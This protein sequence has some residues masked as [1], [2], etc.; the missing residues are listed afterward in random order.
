MC[1]DPTEIT[2]RMASRMRAAKHWGTVGYQ[3]MT[4][5]V[6]RYE[7]TQGHLVAGA[8]ASTLT[9]ASSGLPEGAY[10]TLRTYH[11][12]RVLRLADH[13]RRLASSAGAP[14]DLAVL[15]AALRAALAACGHPES[16]ARI[17]FAPP[18]L[19]VA[20]EPF[21]PPPESAYRDGVA[22]AVVGA[23]RTHFAS[24]D[25][26]FIA[27]AEAE[28][29]R[30]PDGVHEGLLVAEDGALLEG[31]SS[32]FFALLGGVLRTEGDRALPGITRSL[33]LEV[34]EGV[35]P[36]APR[37]VRVDELPSVSEC[38]ITSASRGV[39]PVVHVD[40]LAIGGGV[41]GPVTGALRRRFDARIEAEAEEV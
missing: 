37:A 35:V 33:L 7:W 29:R 28:Y 12:S 24:K 22:C 11:G 16:R 27:T 14:L 15:R 23:Q 9:A 25:T 8:I 19:F 40:G 20:V 26:R 41:P 17:T 5:E 3:P 34:A 1:A 10:T 13:A 4:H 32:N 2:T 36:V 38:F 6:R 39:L 31:L 21:T 30:L 18:R